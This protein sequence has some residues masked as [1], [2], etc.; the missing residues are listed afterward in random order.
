LKGHLGVSVFSKMEPQT[1]QLLR[2]DLQMLILLS[3]SAHLPGQA[4]PQGVTLM[5][6]HTRS[7]SDYALFS[8]L[9]V[10]FRKS[11]L[12][13]KRRFRYQTYGCAYFVEISR[14]WTKYLFSDKLL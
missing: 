14:L 2:G 10:L 13:G 7:L 12:A 5:N 3:R 4:L 1:C 9:C 11:M 8:Q 6:F